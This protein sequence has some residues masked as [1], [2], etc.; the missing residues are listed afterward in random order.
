MKNLEIK[1]SYIFPK[2]FWSTLIDV[3]IGDLQEKCYEIRKNIPCK[4]ASDL[5]SINSE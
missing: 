2:P 5:V 1:K 3:N 4:S